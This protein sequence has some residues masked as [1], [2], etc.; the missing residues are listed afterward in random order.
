[1]FTRVLGTPSTKLLLEEETTIQTLCNRLQHA[2]LSADRRSAVLGLKSFSRQ[3]RE[4]VVQHGLRALLL[5]M[6][7][8]RENAMLVKAVLETLLILFLR[9]QTA[10]EDHARGFISNQSRI[11]NGKYPS[12]LLVDDTELDQFSMW[13]ADE[14]LLTESYLEVLMEIT[15]DLD[16]FHIRLYALQFLEALVAT[17]PIRAKE[18][19]TNIPLAVPTIVSLLNDVNDPIRNETIL[20]LMAIVNKNYN[21][22]KLVAFENTFDRLFEIIDEEGGIRGSILVQDCLTLLTNL[23]MYNASN[24]TLFL[25]TDCVPKL[26]KLLAEP[27]EEEYED[28]LRDEHGNPIPVPPIVWTEQRMQNMS[29]AL[30]ICKLFVDPDNQ[31]LSRNQEILYNSGI[32]FSVLRLIFSPLMEAPIRK[33]ALY[34]AG[35]IIAE[36]PSLQLQFSK[37]DVPYIDP[38]LPP[39]IQSYDKPIPAPLALL[40]WALFTNSV[41]VFEIRLAA[42]YCLHCF[43]KN[44]Q[45]SK[46][47]FITDQIKA[48]K[49]PK[50]YEEL[51]AAALE[52]QAAELSLLGEGSQSPPQEPEPP[53]DPNVK[54]TPYGNIFTTLMDF[55]F[56][57]KIN[58][59]RVWFSAV[60]LLY[61]FEDCPDTKQLVSEMKIGNAAEGEE[62]MSSIQAIAGIL[63]T[64]LENSDPR[65]AIGY[66]LLLTIWIYED[67]DAV[68]DFLADSSIIKSILAFL[69]K[70]SEDSSEIVR[71][72]SS[73]LVGVLY[74][75]S[76]K[77]SPI[78]RAE[79]H[80]LITKA[81]GADNYTLTVKKFKE[82]DSFKHYDEDI[83]TEIE[84]DSTGLPMVFFI[85]EYIELIKD[86]LYRIRKALSRDPAFEPRARISFEIFEELENKNVELRSSLKELEIETAETER[87]LEKKIIER[88]LEL[89]LT[90]D[91]LEKSKR[92]LQEYVESEE[93]LT[94]KVQLLSAD[95]K[96]VEADREKYQTSSKKLLEELQTVSKL[97]TSNES[98]LAQLKQK[99]SDTEAAKQKAEDGIN[100]MSRE[101]FQLTKLQKEAEQKIAKFDKEIANLKAQHAKETEDY[102]SQ[103][104]VARKTIEELRAKIRVLESQL[105]D[106]PSGNSRDVSRLREF[107]N[108]ISELQET[109]E[110]L[111]NKLKS[112]A[113]VVLDLKVERNEFKE[114]AETLELELTKAYEDLETFGSLMEEID[115][116]KTQNK[117]IQESAPD[118]GTSDVGTLKRQIE[119]ISLLKA[120]LEQE[121]S[122]AESEL[123][124]FRK[125][126]VLETVH[127]EIG[128]E[129]SLEPATNGTKEVNGQRSLDRTADGDSK[130][131]LD[132][133]A[134]ESLLMQIKEKEDALSKIQEEMKDLRS[135]FDEQSSALD[136]LR[137]ESMQEKENLMT[138]LANAKKELEEIQKA[139][140]APATAESEIVEA[141]EEMSKEI[142]SESSELQQLDEALAKAHKRIE[143]L[144]KNIELL[145]ENAS[146]SLKNFQTSEATL[147]AQVSEL[148]TSKSQLQ[149]SLSE[150]KEKYDKDIQAKEE[151]Y[152][153]LDSEF[154]D[155]ELQFS[156]LEKSKDE[157]DAKHKLYYKESSVKI[158]QLEDE[159]KKLRESLSEM[160][161]D[162]DA[163]SG[164]FAELERRSNAI[165]SELQ[166][167][168]TTLQ[169]IHNKGVNLAAKDKVVAE[170]KETLA[171]TMED[172]GT[173]YQKNRAMVKEKLALATQIERAE[174][175]LSKSN[176]ALSERDALLEKLKNELETLHVEYESHKSEQLSAI[177]RNITQIQELEKK[178]A[179]CEQNLHDAHEKHVEEK[180]IIVQTS[181]DEVKEYLERIAGLETSLIDL[182][183][184]QEKASGQE[185]EQ[186][187]SEVNL[188]NQELD[189]LKKQHEALQTQLSESEATV[190]ELKGLE[191]A[192]EE[193][194]AALTNELKQAES[195]LVSKGESLATFE[196]ELESN[197]ARLEE[198]LGD[199]EQAKEEIK[200]QKLRVQ[201]LETEVE[202]LNREKTGML[203]QIQNLET[204]VSVSMRDAEAKAAQDSSEA[205]SKEAYALQAEELEALKI[206]NAKLTNTLDEKSAELQSASEQL[207]IALQKLKDL[208]SSEDAL[209]KKVSELE[210]EFLK[211]TEA[212]EEIKLVCNEKIKELE[213]S[214]SELEKHR[215]AAQNSNEL[216]AA[217]AACQAEL[218]LAKDEIDHL[219]VEVKEAA[220]KLE[221]GDLNRETADA[222]LKDTVALHEKQIEEKESEVLAMKTEIAKLKDELRTT[223]ELTSSND[224]L[225]TSKQQL[226]EEIKS[227]E[228]TVEEKI[229]ALT[230]KDDEVK[231]LKAELKSVQSQMLEIQ[232]LRDTVTESLTELKATI[233]ALEDKL[234][235]LE[236]KLSLQ[237]ETRSALAPQ[238]DTESEL[239]TKEQQEK[240]LAELAR[241]KL[242][243]EDLKL[244]AQFEIEVHYDT[245]EKVNKN[246]KEKST[247]LAMVTEENEKLK[248]ELSTLQEMTKLN[249][250]PSNVEVD[251]TKLNAMESELQTAREEKAQLAQKLVSQ[252]ERAKTTIVQMEEKFHAQLEQEAASKI[253]MQRDFEDLMLMWEEQEAKLRKYRQQLR[254]SGH[255]VSDDEAGEDLT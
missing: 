116:L 198:L 78:S 228:S 207:D 95:L 177:S 15:L 253:K 246:L 206:E 4:T 185:A 197:Q 73:V 191:I 144:E 147:K 180:N 245:M 48:S 25:E 220:E 175:S 241:L 138:E 130:P 158:S 237:T 115:E 169:A 2:T 235:I 9:S 81:L 215:D 209:Q 148:E 193:K 92:E 53:L 137:E 183:S 165:S 58:P 80:E 227:L 85:P 54:Q 131:E 233:S 108:Q 182:K 143:D 163:I 3:F 43:F 219:K 200:M 99:L 76:T 202:N 102:K 236:E 36:N 187:K 106:A 120:K 93:L 238:D 12:P 42:L 19:L 159:V 123:A 39:Q 226:E 121:L 97:N 72:M 128:T 167:K 96:S 31:L 29:I 65:I 109:N 139:S 45:E 64:N 62:V 119:E 146:A 55:D 224:D 61:L 222:S 56:E 68:N 250:E 157:L 17:R 170:I 5:T 252:S 8:D 98:S 184:E 49:N 232:E 162:R 69:S 140:S 216:E 212:S 38:S 127:H 83:D 13:I 122:N 63:T 66:L 199:A 153:D 40:N 51:E 188:A 201:S 52:A 1:M 103:V 155:L 118:L 247:E 107:Q 67:F 37:I 168:V 90:N 172:L 20:L 32:F 214:I 34:V 135:N 59:Y 150:L 60:V 6:G 11:Q 18:C 44:N 255:D 181:K 71:G 75:F 114:K 213:T 166:A 141:P 21:I 211:V 132:N 203:S 161:K 251:S 174:E 192:N 151:A 221:A 110:D 160:E 74:E 101:L 112:A 210:E 229:T 7:K 164:E 89:S 156:N 243:I 239:L 176:E 125:L 88:E 33:T 208:A 186:L 234:S 254:A 82:H 77:N 190:A 149:E 225:A 240:H 24:Q 104:E 248:S 152:D 133:K 179:E 136:T 249:V 205:A 196:A 242:E 30:E 50:Y 100:K 142:P 111:M 87:Q 14:V 154:L 171:A 145:S 57:V 23:L 94:Q 22:Q 35:E 223:Q 117:Q 105:Q 46:V 218:K 189:S 16:D 126:N 41:H 244:E 204:E 84:K 86:N 27:V 113:S 231:E 70:N 47:A 194:L 217:L 134:D 195:E 10:N 124:K 79:L 28:G 26:A 91:L 173:A 129:T 230:S 178:L